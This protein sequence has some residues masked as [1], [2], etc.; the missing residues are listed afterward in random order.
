MAAAQSLAWRH[1]F[2]VR[3]LRRLSWYLLAGVTLVAAAWLL[4]GSEPRRLATGEI[5]TLALLPL[6]A[7]ALVAV[8]AVPLAAALARRPLV[9]ADHYALRVRPGILRTLLLP[10]ASVA[11]VTAIT[12]GREPLL[13]VRCQ[14]VRGQPADRPRW[15]DQRVLHAAGR[16]TAGYH[17]AVRMDEFNGDP[18]SLLASIAAWAPQRVVVLDRLS[19]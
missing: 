14:P 18:T 19:G 15:Y 5:N 4:F 1:R 11:E 16:P 8:G 12:V 3:A 10:W 7:A 9:A 2:P 6:C 13:L 17:L